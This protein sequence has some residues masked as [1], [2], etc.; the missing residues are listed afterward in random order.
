MSCTI[1]RKGSNCSFQDWHACCLLYQR[2]CCVERYTRLAQRSRISCV[3]SEIS[4]PGN[5]RQN[6][7]TFKFIFITWQRCSNY[8]SVQIS[9]HS[10]AKH[11]Y[12]YSIQLFVCF[13]SLL[14]TKTDLIRLFCCIW[15]DRLNSSM[16]H[17]CTSSFVWSFPSSKKTSGSSVL[18]Y[19]TRQ[20][21]QFNA[22]SM[23]IV[24]WFVCFV[25]FDYTD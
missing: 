15:L 9:L 13:V 22:E 6:N 2:L 20:T 24:I 21:K 14:L 8:Q 3:N 16:H 25:V 10:I 11:M 1:V 19:L 23:H 4:T 5:A 18:L 17:Q 7:C 12:T